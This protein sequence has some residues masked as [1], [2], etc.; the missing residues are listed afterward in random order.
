L[1]CGSNARSTFAEN[2]ERSGGKYAEAD[3]IIL[4]AAEDIRSWPAKPARVKP[5]S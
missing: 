2:P 5:K 3:N 4:W 1:V